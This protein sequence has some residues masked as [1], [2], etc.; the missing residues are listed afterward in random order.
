MTFLH[1]SFMVCD[2]ALFQTTLCALRV[3]LDKPVDNA[4]VK[5][6][7]LALPEKTQDIKLYNVGRLY[8]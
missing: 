4:R 7:A 2:G 1:K 5:S 3:G 8:L 6:G